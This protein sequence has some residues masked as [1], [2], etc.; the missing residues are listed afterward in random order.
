MIQ[1]NQALDRLLPNKAS[2]LIFLSY[3][4]LFV[5]SGLLITGAHK[6]YPNGFDQTILIIW[7]EVIK[8]F[9]CVVVYLVKN[10]GSFEILLVDIHRNRLL[11]ALYLA[12]AFLYCLYNNLSYINLKLVDPTTYYCLMQFRIVLTG[13]I[14]QILFKRKLTITQWISLLVLTLGCIIKEW[15][16]IINKTSQQGVNNL[17]A[18]KDVSSEKGSNAFFVTSVTSLWVTSSI[19]L[20]MFCSCFAG[21]YNEYLLKDSSTAASADVILQNIFMYIDSA[22]CNFI[23]Y[24]RSHSDNA[25]KL[26]SD[27]NSYHLLKD[28]LIIILVL[29]NALSGLVA[30]LFLKSLNSILKTFAASLELF[31]VALLAWIIFHDPI[32]IYTIIA[33]ILVSLALTVYAQNPVSVDPPNRSFLERDGFKPLPTVDEDDEDYH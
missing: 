26:S 6:I 7:T 32:D 1:L 31:A 30:S 4:T 11:F 2:S 17:N 20:Q 28:P 8:L 23:L 24:L 22:I 12:P 21:V 19:L 10:G 16:L 33:L 29:N 15:G 3:I 9:I 27:M 5:S 13:I 14:Y 18:T 25:D